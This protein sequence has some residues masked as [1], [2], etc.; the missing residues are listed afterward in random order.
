MVWE[1]ALS[2][3]TTQELPRRRY[4]ARQKLPPRTSL[5]TQRTRGT[6]RKN[7][8]GSYLCVL[9]VLCVD[10]TVDPLHP[11]AACVTSPRFRPSASSPAQPPVSSF[12]N[13]RSLSLT[14]CS[15]SRLRRPSSP[16]SRVVE[17]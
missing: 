16:P 11:R 15:R 1:S 10:A 14:C 17:R 13:R 9:R 2:R 3:T 6:R 12:L 4:S 5:P 7:L 8:Y